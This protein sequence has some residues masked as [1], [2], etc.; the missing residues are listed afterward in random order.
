[1]KPGEIIT[2]PSRTCSNCGHGTPS[3]TSGLYFSVKDTP[4]Q[5][6]LF[7]KGWQPNGAPD[8]VQQI[9]PTLTESNSTCGEWKLKI[10]VP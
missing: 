10:I 2:A 1:M 8:V 5:M 6:F 3:P 4:P 9:S 7:L